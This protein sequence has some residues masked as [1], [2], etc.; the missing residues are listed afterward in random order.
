MRNSARG[1]W[2]SAMNAQPVPERRVVEGGCPLAGPRD[3]IARDFSRRASFVAI[4]MLATLTLAL[5]AAAE[6]R[7]RIANGTLE[8]AMDPRSGIRA[9]KGIPFAAPPVGNL[10][11]REPQPVTNWEG[12][13]KAD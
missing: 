13:R 3:L 8:G 5:P 4:V 2:R 10:R 9:F 11:W 7:V 12:V 1:A 6:T